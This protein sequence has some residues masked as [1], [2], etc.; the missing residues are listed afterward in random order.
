MI[1]P[2]NKPAIEVFESVP[3]TIAKTLGGMIGARLAPA[4]IVPIESLVS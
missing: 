1:P 2:I 4:S 3:I